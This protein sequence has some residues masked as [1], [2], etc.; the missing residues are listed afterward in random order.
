MEERAKR[1]AKNTLLLYVRMLAT[2]CVGLFTSR[3]ILKTLGVIDF[4]IYNVVGGFVAMFSLISSPLSSATSR[5]ITIELGKGNI[6]RLKAVFT[7][8][9]NTQIIFIIICIIIA[10]LF[11]IWFLNE[12][13]VIP[14][15]RLYAAN[16]VFQLSLLSLAIEMLSVPY[17][18]CIIAHER[19]SAFAYISIYEVIIKLLIAWL[20][21]IS[22]IDKL[23]FYA[24]LMCLVSLS[25]RGIYGYYC[26]KKFVEC[27]YSFAWD[28]DLLKQMFG[29]AGW[30]II[31]ISS[32]M[33]REQGGNL[34]VNLFA[35]PTVNAAKAIASQVNGAVYRFSSNFMMAVNPQIT[36][37]YAV[38][39]HEYMMKLVYQSARLSCYMLFFLSLP[40]M[41]NIQ[42]ILEIW[43]GIVPAHTAEFVNLVLV[44]TICESLSNPLITVMLATGKIRNYQ[45]VVGGLNLLNLPLS[46][47]LL[48]LGCIPE[49]ILIVAILLSLVC[50]LARLLMLKNMI[51]LSPKTFLKKVIFPVIKVSVGASIIPIIISVNVDKNFITFVCICVISILCSSS[52]IYFLGCNVAEQNL[53]RNKIHTLI[54]RKKS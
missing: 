24:T 35:G 23:I 12:K 47:M 5:F 3:V 52:A 48:K 45:I 42:Y 29:F 37:S 38:N 36:K 16:W 34:L 14:N 40:I 50:L 8:S 44:L 4:G 53:I 15:E 28:K 32:G 46:Y 51:S 7:T 21:L 31:G 39:D 10:E 13:M 11:G 6:N 19:M 30:N 18:A 1:I 22:P 33:L 43:L 2:M 27:K 17:N 9:I 25:I 54:I 26:Q 49:T 41:T 20:I